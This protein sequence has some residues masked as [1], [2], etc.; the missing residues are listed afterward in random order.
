MDIKS[1]EVNQVDVGTLF[2]EREILA[3]R[4]PFAPRVRTLEKLRHSELSPEEKLFASHSCLGR[5]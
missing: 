4:H 3:G 5:P 2:L 1:L